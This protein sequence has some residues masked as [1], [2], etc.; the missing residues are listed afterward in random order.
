MMHLI[1]YTILLQ[2]TYKYSHKC[3]KIPTFVKVA[4]ILKKIFYTPK[5]DQ[6]FKNQNDTNFIYHL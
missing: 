1:I 5:L 4:L 2:K 6:E 3:K